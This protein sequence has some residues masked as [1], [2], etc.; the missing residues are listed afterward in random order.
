[1]TWKEMAVYIHIPKYITEGSISTGK[2]LY[3]EFF[4]SRMIWTN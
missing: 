1:M 3:Q 2:I 4:L